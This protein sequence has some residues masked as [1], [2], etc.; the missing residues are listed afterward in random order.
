M[1]QHEENL[2]RRQCVSCREY[3]EQWPHRIGVPETRAGKEGGLQQPY[4]LG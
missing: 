3:F 4:H 1:E 2:L